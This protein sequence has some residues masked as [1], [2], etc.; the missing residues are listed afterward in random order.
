M[1]DLFQKIRKL[2]PVK[3]QRLASWLNRFLIAPP[4]R[5]SSW[6]GTFTEVTTAKVVE[7]YRKRGVVDEHEANQKQF[8]LLQN[9]LYRAPVKKDAEQK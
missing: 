4:D 9:A 5:L 6:K 7:I 2:K 1:A 3:G 8:G